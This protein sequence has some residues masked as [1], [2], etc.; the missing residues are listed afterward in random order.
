VDSR[1]TTAGS[2][3]PARSG[4]TADRKRV[5]DV[6]RYRYD[7]DYDHCYGYDYGYGY[8]GDNS[9]FSRPIP[10]RSASWKSTT[11]SRYLQNPGF[12]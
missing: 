11:S 10:S 8:E 2:T 3:W 7:Y 4:R 1:P 12:F 9:N 6:Y 5:G